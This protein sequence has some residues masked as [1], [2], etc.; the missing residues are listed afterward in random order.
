M[1]MEYKDPGRRGK[2]IIVL[3]V[4]LALAAGAA[5]FYLI[6]QAQQ[7]AGQGEL[8]RVGVVV[9]TRDIPARKPIE[10]DDVTIRQIPLDPTNERGVATDVQQVVGRVL[11]VPA[12][13]GQMVT[14]NM[15]ASSASGGQFSILGPTETVAPDS[16]AWRAVSMTVPDDRA[17]GG[18]LLPNQT[19]DVIVTA[20]VNVPAGL[21][22]EG[23]FYTDKSTKITY[24]NMV[25]LAKAGTFYIV[26]ASLAVAEEITHLQASGT[27]QFSMVLRPEQDIRYADASQLGATTNLFIE[28]Y[29]LPIPEVFPPG[30]GPI[31]SAEPTETPSSP[32]TAE[33]SPS[34]SPSP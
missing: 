20:T 30:E 6:S 24:Q 7:Q 2:V 22:A 25:I 10:A 3:G 29:G 1:E 4:I 23:E 21:L 33:P 18:M 26:K 14:T 8:Q 15:L 17:V 27:A 34:A 9:A 19:V 31:P 28:R 13:Q 16:E 5:A 32:P 12:F 11:A